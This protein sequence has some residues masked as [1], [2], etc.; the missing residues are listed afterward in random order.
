MDPNTS[1]TTTS[2]PP[3]P[4]YVQDHAP[5]KEGHSAEHVSHAEP[6][7]AHHIAS[8]VHKTEPSQDSEAS[9]SSDHS[10]ATSPS[11]GKKDPEVDLIRQT[12][13][14]LLIGAWLLKGANPNA[15]TDAEKSL[16]NIEVSLTP[17]RL[18]YEITQPGASL[19]I[20]YEI[21]CISGI[22]FKSDNVISMAVELSEPP[23]FSA[24]E[25]GKWIKVLDF[26][27][28][29]ATHYKRHTLDFYTTV[30]PF[31]NHL[32]EQDSHIKELMEQGL[33]S[34]TADQSFASVPTM[35]CDWDK[36]NLAI[37]HCVECGTQNFCAECDEV[38]HRH[39]EKRTHRRIPAHQLSHA[40]SGRK[41]KNKKKKSERCRCGT[42]ATKQ[43]LGFPCTGN[44][45]PCYSEGKGCSSC[46]CK[47]CKNPNNEGDEKRARYEE[48]ED[49]DGEL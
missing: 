44:R 8:V 14:K 18:K 17:S 47:G 19:M 40:S 49:G 38:L 16:F 7:A 22:S 1:T 3:P 26:T 24:K 43:T 10:Q 39:P 11:P 32:L 27:Q 9:K 4:S 29:N 31:I 28:G 25:E 33:S 41:R 30:Q 13:S 36:E 42:G 5:S 2:L 45:C 12:A 46:G 21:S 23:S 48:D 6:D 15:T 34:D 35:M 37:L 20:D